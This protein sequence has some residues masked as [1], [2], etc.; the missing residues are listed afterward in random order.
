MFALS[1]LQDGK[2]GVSQLLTAMFAILDWKGSSSVNL[3]V[4]T[5]IMHES[6]GVNCQSCRLLVL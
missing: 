4:T 3:L 1:L 6:E 2:Q 5:D